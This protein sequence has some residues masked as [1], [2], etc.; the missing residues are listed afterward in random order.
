M[1]DEMGNK[2]GQEGYYTGLT[3]YARSKGFTFVVANPGQDVPNSFVGT[4]DTIF[5]YE[6]AGLPQLGTL[7]AA[8]AGYASENFGIIPYAVSTLDASYVKSALQSVHY[9]Y[10]TND[11]LPNPWDSLSAYFDGLLG[12]LE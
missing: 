2:P 9:V 10:A 7:G 11:D 3:T 8:H 4:V 12:A 5:I 6:S 1:I